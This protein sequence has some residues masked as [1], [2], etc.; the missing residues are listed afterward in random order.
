MIFKHAS[1]VVLWFHESA[2]L[3]LEFL[4]GMI[5]RF[6]CPLN[7]D[8]PSTEWSCLLYPDPWP[9]LPCFIAHGM[10]CLHRTW[11]VSCL[12]R[13]QGVSWL[14]C[15]IHHVCRRR[16]SNMWIA[17]LLGQ[18]YSGTITWWFLFM[19]FRLCT[20]ACLCLAVP[21]YWHYAIYYLSLFCFSKHIIIVSF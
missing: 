9:M 7:R 8:F 15:S 17:I 13:P 12:Y 16:Y 10:L 6:E 4:L 14:S 11:A 20:H 2:P 19:L 18:V 21:L 5:G 3:S 1:F